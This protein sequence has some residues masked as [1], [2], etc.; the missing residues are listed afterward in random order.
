MYEKGARLKELVKIVINLK[1]GI[2]LFRNTLTEA[3]MY[4][5]K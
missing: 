5:F 4:K 3:Y 2:L 1:N